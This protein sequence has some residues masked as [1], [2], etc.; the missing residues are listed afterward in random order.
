MLQID[1]AIGLG[2][3]ENASPVRQPL[4]EPA[5]GPCVERL[6]RSERRR[7]PAFGPDG[8]TTAASGTAPNS[9]VRRVNV[10]T[11]DWTTR[12]SS[13]VAEHGCKYLQVGAILPVG[14]LR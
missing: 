13:R 2:K 5:W 11:R 1:L 12:A 14:Y 7:C 10:G 9:R 3:R 4:R 6:Q 8:D